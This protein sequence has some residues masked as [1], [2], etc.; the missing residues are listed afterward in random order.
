MQMAGILNRKRVRFF[1]LCLIV[2]LGAYARFAEFEWHF[3]HNDDIATAKTIVGSKS[4]GERNLFCVPRQWT[5]AP[6][7]FLITYFLITPDQTYRELLFWGRLPSVCFGILGLIALLLFYRRYDKP[8]S[9]KVLPALTLLA[10]SWENIIMAKQMH[11]YALGVTAVIFLI[12]LFMENLN[13]PEISLGVMAVNVLL[14]GLLSW[15]HYQVL[16]FVPPFFLILLVYA[17]YRKMKGARIFRN[18]FAGGMLYGL[19]FA[20]LFFFFLRKHLEYGGTD[21]WS[22]GPNNEFLLIFREGMSV[23]EKIGYVVSFYIKNFYLIVQSNMGFIPYEHP[24]LLPISAVLFLFFIAGIIRFFRSG[25]LR[26]RFLG[27]FF[28]ALA[29]VW[30][31]LILLRKITFAPTRHS[32]VLLPVMVITVAEGLDWFLERIAAFGR[33]GISS[34]KGHLG[35]SLLVIALFFQSFPAMLEARRDPF[36]ED[37]MIKILRK[38]DVDALISYSYTFPPEMMQSVC[39]YF[40][41]R[42]LGFTEETFMTDGTRPYRTVA[43][44]SHRCDLDPGHYREAMAKIAHINYIRKR[45]IP[46]FWVPLSEL[47]ILYSKAF[48]SNVEIEFS[49]RLPDGGNNF[50]FYILRRAGPLSD[51]IEIHKPGRG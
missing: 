10:F 43:W 48:K 38:Y 40:N 46:P 9:W 24:L 3:T 26:K 36:R 50:Y 16:F 29:L 39:S 2:L 19:I 25:E 42:Q 13:R 15:M 4:A 33:F 49:N 21:N 14:L 32:L 28:V 12:C 22:R 47:R 44:V 41:Y 20:P 7:Q 6:F 51:T 30:I 34:W 5:Y 31:I 1:F 35:S 23:W 8:A 27:S 18:F 37:E 11:N 17:F 45:R